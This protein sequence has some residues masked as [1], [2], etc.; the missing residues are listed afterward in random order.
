MYNN[1]TLQNVLDYW[2]TSQG[3]Y[4]YQGKY[5]GG[6]D[7]RTFTREDLSYLP[8]TYLDLYKK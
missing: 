4:L 7:F 1:C 5:K 3:E 8:F 2:T 6:R